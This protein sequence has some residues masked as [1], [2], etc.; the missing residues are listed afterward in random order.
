MSDVFGLSG[1]RVGRYE[2]Q[3]VLGSGGM[4]VVYDAIDPSLGRHVALKVLPPQLVAD[5]SRLNRFVQEAR[6]ASAL[7]HPNVVSIYE[8]GHDSANGRDV[9]FIAMEL[10]DGETLRNVIAGERMTPSRAAEVTAQIADVAASAHASGIVHRDLKPENVM[11]TRNGHVKVLDFGLAKL[12][13]R[14]LSSSEDSA[15]A[16]QETASGAILGTAGYMAPE[17]ARGQR[18]DHRADIFAIGCILYEMLSGKRAFRASSPVET[19]NEIITKDPPPVKG[20]PPEYDRILRKSLAKEPDARYQTA[21][22]MALD[23]RAAAAG[24]QRR[25]LNVKTL[26]AVAIAAVVLGALWPLVTTRRAERV[27]PA[28]TNTAPSIAVL[29]FQTAQ[30]ADAWIGVGMADS[31]I[32]RLTRV[33]ELVVRPTSAVLDAQTNNPAADLNVEHLVEGR[34]LREGDRIRINAQLTDVGEKRVLWADTFYAT[35]QELLTAQDDISERV[36][37]ALLNQLTSS[38]RVSIRQRET[39]NPEA[40]RLYVEG[41]YLTSQLTPAG[42][43]EAVEKLRKATTLDPRYARAH[44]ALAR[45]L[46]ISAARAGDEWLEAKRSIETALR[47]EPD[48]PEAVAVKA[49]NDFWNDWDRDV[50]P[51]FQRA[52]RLSPSDPD[53]H[54][55]YAWFLMAMGRFE[56]SS[57]E[58]SRTR[59]LDPR[60]VS[61]ESDVGLCLYMARQYPAALTHLR[62]VV[63]RNPT[64]PWAQ[65]FLARALTAAGQGGE[66]A[67]LVAPTIATTRG[68]IAEFVVE[69]ARGQAVAGDM[70]T[71]RKTLAPL[72]SQP[73]VSRYELAAAEMS[74]G[75]RDRAIQLLHEAVEQR[76][77]WVSWIKVDPRFDPLRQ[78]PRFASILKLAG[79]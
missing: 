57:R 42:V 54:H 29:P 44:V 32:T 18:A 53:I 48:L 65:L 26:F 1:S 10:I 21:K 45:A 39:D 67:R 61:A 11:L 4:G 56:E 6:S 55:M 17:Q 5:R 59:Q 20:L 75:D 23:L 28:A 66:A 2:V 19:L 31:I 79:F 64:Y 33:H 12:A 41:R 63:E 7:N 22:D 69:A 71:A 38:Q 52:L 15:T 34:V 16:V 14:A 68:M 25:A 36:A 49:A 74:L 51:L 3:S 47:L 60:N 70:T 30:P 46:S 40:Y 35:S 43:K 58:L 37:S 9:H 8:I 77:K 13:E 78:D 72:Y 27:A 50:E 76:D 73:W 24:P 62:Q